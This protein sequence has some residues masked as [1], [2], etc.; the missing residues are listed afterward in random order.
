MAIFLYIQQGTNTYRLFSLPTRP[1][2]QWWWCPDCCCG[3]HSFLPGVIPLIIVKLVTLTPPTTFIVCAYLP[4]NLLD[5]DLVFVTEA[6][7]Q[8]PLNTNILLLG[9]FN[10]PSIDWQTL[11]APTTQ[12]QSFC[13]ELFSLNLSQVITVPTHKQGNTLDLV[14][15]RCPTDILDLVIHPQVNPLISDHFVITFNISHGN[16]H[17]NRTEPRRIFNYLNCEAV[18]YPAGC[19]NVDSAWL[20]LKNVLTAARDQFV[21]TRTVHHNDPKWFSP[22]IRHLIKRTRTARCKFN[23]IRSPV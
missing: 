22:E 10:L 3:I 1:R 2:F 6:L 23:R 8:L 19:W 14:F 4:P 12:G 16:L 17:T 15:T 18:I 20:S 13:D 7:K 5:R 11:S 21:P 9:D